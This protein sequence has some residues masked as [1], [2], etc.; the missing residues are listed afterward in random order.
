MLEANQKK[1]F[2]TIALFFNSSNWYQRTT[3]KLSNVSVSLS[4]I[5]A[6]TLHLNF[7]TTFLQYYQWLNCNRTQRNAVLQPAENDAKRS[8]TQIFY[9]RRRTVK[10]NALETECGLT[11]G[12]TATYDA[13]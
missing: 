5:T 8:P 4:P 10:G 12:Y 13:S 3:A 2:L 1:E 6:Q 9:G 7:V 11:V